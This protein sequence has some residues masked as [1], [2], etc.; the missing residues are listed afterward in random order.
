[1]DVLQ[2]PALARRTRGTRTC[3]RVLAA[4]HRLDVHE[5]QDV[6][7]LS[8]RPSVVVPEQRDSTR[9]QIEPLSDSLDEPCSGRPSGSG[10]WTQRSD[11]GSS[12]PSRRGTRSGGKAR[13]RGTNRSAGRDARRHLAR[14]RQLHALRCP[15]RLPERPVAGARARVP[16][17]ASCSRRGSRCG[18]TC[19]WSSRSGRPRTGHL[20]GLAR[21][22]P[23]AR[24]SP[25]DGSRCPSQHRCWDRTSALISSESVSGMRS[26]LRRVK[27]SLG[28]VPRGASYQMT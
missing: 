28:F 6:G 10:I 15:S 7:A 3:C 11:R 27:S 26:R 8:A 19:A 9:S 14:R 5:Q 13:G 4:Q 16:Q 21:S 18:S 20:E 1:M 12:P 22:R 23:T 17:S 25:A 2:R 24:R